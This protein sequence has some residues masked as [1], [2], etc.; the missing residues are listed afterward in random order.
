MDKLWYYTVGGTE[1]RGP[2]MERDFCAKIQAGEIAPTELVWTQGMPTWAPL[3]EQ[4]A[5]RP[6]IPNA[7]PTGATPPPAPPSAPSTNSPQAARLPAFG[8]WLSFVGIASIIGGA[9][10]TITCVGI[11]VGILM[12]LS[13]TAALG[14]KA[15]FGDGNPSPEQLATGMAKLRTFFVLSGV[16]IILKLLAVLIFLF[17]LGGAALALSQMADSF[18]P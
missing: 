12:I 18:S 17:N 11:P 2:L 4:P 1:Q 8:G 16:I 5:L 13:G 10:L 3:Q 15:A 7:N 9:L 14:A 6:F